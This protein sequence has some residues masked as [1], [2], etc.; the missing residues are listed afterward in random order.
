[1]QQWGDTS[2]ICHFAE[3]TNFIRKWQRDGKDAAG[4]LETSTSEPI[5]FFPVLHLVSDHNE[6]PEWSKQK[7]VRRMERK[8]SKKGWKLQILAALRCSKIPSGRRVLLSSVSLWPLHFAFGRDAF[9][10]GLQRCQTAKLKK[11]E[12][13]G[14]AAAAAAEECW[15]AAES[16]GCKCFM[17]F[18]RIQTT[19][20]G[21]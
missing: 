11:K 21:K 10:C 20:R 14:R 6:M 12:F 5:R 15:W 18:Y 17:A 9:I 13:K 8:T 1:M 7:W 3:I 19:Q 16:G 4:R 2:F